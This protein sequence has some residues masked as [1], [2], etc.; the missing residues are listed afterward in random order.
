VQWGWIEGS[1]AGLSDPREQRHTPNWSAQTGQ[2]GLAVGRTLLAL[3]SGAGVAAVSIGI[4]V[5]G[6]DGC[7]VVFATEGR[8]IEG[9][10]FWANGE[11]VQAARFAARVRKRRPAGRQ[12]GL[13]SAES[14]KAN[15]S[16]A[17]SSTFLVL[18]HRTRHYAL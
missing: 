11:A 1:G 10:R 2:G 9:V 17:A 16:A 5:E 4:P 7:S 13:H 14:S 18:L 3:E 15:R 12:E 8:N 6:Q